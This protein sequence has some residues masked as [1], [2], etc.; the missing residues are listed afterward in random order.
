[1]VLLPALADDLYCDGLELDPIVKR[2]SVV[3]ELCYL[4]PVCGCCCVLYEVPEK[5]EKYLELAPD[6]EYD[7]AVVEDGMSTKLIHHLAE[8]RFLEAPLRHMLTGIDIPASLGDLIECA[9]GDGKGELPVKQ[10]RRQV[11]KQSLRHP[12]NHASIN[13]IVYLRCGVTTTCSG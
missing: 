13:A 12:V 10:E 6:K 9:L 5:S 1:M 2:P 7:V 3:D 11:S 4:I 8:V